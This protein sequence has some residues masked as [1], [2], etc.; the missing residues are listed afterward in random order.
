MTVTIRAAALNVVLVFVHVYW[1]AGYAFGPPRLTSSGSLRVAI[2][3]APGPWWGWAFLVGAALTVA[4]PWLRRAGSAA[5]H[6]LASLPL[7]AWS[8]AL[9]TAQALGYSE[10]WGGVLAFLAAA[11][12]HALLVRARYSREAGRA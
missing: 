4:A 11:A 5:A 2:E 3:W 12:L 8:T 10:G 9:L 7:L 1:G 6:V